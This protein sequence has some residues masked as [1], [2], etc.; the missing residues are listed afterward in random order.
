MKNC[1]NDILKYH[2]TE[3]TLGAGQQAE[4]RERR[5]TNRDRL[6]SG[7]KKL[8]R[9]GPD[10]HV[11]QG[12]YAMK[13]MVQHPDNNHDIDDGAAFLPEQLLT[14]AGEPMTPE[15]A[16][17]MV[18]KALEQDGRLSSPPKV[19]KNCV[20]I[21]Y[22]AGYH[23]D[24]PVYRKTTDAFGKVTFELAGKDAW[25]K[26]NPREITEWFDR[27][28]AAN[29]RFGE[30][31]PQLRRMTREMK[32]FA[33][34]QCGDNDAPAGLILT[35]LV[36]EAFLVARDREDEA[37]RGVLQNLKARIDQNWH[38]YN[39][40]DRTE[41]L[42]FKKLSEA[43][44]VALKKLAV[45]DDLACSRALA[46]DAWD[47][48]FKTEFFSNLERQDRERESSASINPARPVNKQGGGTY[49]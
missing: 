3:V 47:Q 32:K 12:S 13:T 37:F 18:K 9:K 34:V 1:S 42:K 25:R 5:N 8:N 16:K 33:R 10:E 45:L 30:N 35:I 17:Q 28:V 41:E 14:D 2:D 43:I 46:R 38:V 27:Q 20:R 24:I 21:E 6:K 39:P 40:A 29:K 31:D 22:E 49:A 7:L 23:V 26:T 11:V 48:V 19:L 15:Q 44:N 36:D 4:M